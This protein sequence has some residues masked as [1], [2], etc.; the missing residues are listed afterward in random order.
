M[1]NELS[2]YFVQCPYCWQSFEITVDC[3]IEHQM[4][5]ED[6][7]VCCR[8]ILLDIQVDEF[9]GISVDARNENE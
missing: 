3:S 7:E 6:C 5:T 1:R 8:P 2:E 4:Y 9:G